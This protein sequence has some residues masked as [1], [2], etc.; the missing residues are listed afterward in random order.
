[1]SDV[2]EIEAEVNESVGGT[3]GVAGY[4]YLPDKPSINGVTLVDNK[5]AASLGL[6]DDVQ[7]DGES[8]VD[9]SV[10]NLTP[11]SGGSTSS[12]VNKAGL[13]PKPPTI[14]ETG[15][16]HILTDNGWKEATPQPDSSIPWATKYSPTFSG[17]P[18]APTAAVGTNT[19]QIATTAF[20]HDEILEVPKVYCGEEAPE[21]PNAMVW[22]DTNGDPYPMEEEIAEAVDEWVTAHPEAVTTVQDGAV[23]KPKLDSNLKSKIDLVDTNATHIANLDA[24]VNNLATLQEGSTTGDAELIAARTVGSTTYQNLHTAIDTEFTNVKS[25]LD[26]IATFSS[27]RFDSDSLSRGDYLYPDG[28]IEP[29]ANYSTTDYIPVSSGET[30]YWW[31]KH[32]SVGWYSFPARCLCAYDASKNAVS[33]S[34]G[35]WIGGTYAVPSGISFIRLTISHEYIDSCDKFYLGKYPIADADSKYLAYG[36]NHLF[37]EPQVTENTSNISVLASQFK[38]VNLFDKTAITADSY[39]NPSDGTIIGGEGFFASDFIDVSKYQTIKVSKT[40]LFALYKADKTYLSAPSNTNSIYADLSV[41]VS[42]A[43]Y[44]R[45]S[46]WD[47]YLNDAQVGQNISSANYAPY[48]KFV[49]PNLIIE[50]EQNQIVVDASGNG[51]YTSFT[52]ALYDNVNSGIDILVKAGTYDIVAEYEALFG[53]ENVANMADSDSAIFN[54]FQFGVI[55]S[56]RKIEFASGAHLVCDW[57][58][59]VVDATHRFCP[60]R[61]DYNVEIIGLDLNATATFYA[62]HDDYGLVDEPYTVKYENCRVSGDFV[63]GNC[64]GGG[65]KAYSRHIINNCWFDNGSGLTAVRYHNTN[66][67]GAEPEIYVSNSYFSSRLTFNYYGLQTTKMKAY[68]NNCKAS[69]IVKIQESESYSVDNVELHKWCCEET[70]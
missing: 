14:E 46:T 41:D 40:H 35:Y 64:I 63:N 12:A 11:F 27:N 33:A 50:N 37:I 58:G 68:V 20:V 25:D 13:V 48:G 32:P 5:S 26:S 54:G 56:N 22:V 69:S 59:H 65:C 15:Q 44:I 53:A 38:F 49:M 51:D 10:A 23:S 62:I 19:T 67:V 8:V 1:M 61:V 16:W 29:D 17:I 66:A 43:S 28:T 3:G 39:V 24:L 6:V 4:H 45:F 18:K 30:V 2:I 9:G 47:E 36:E 21:D 60:L 57:T 55:L 42:G 70:V 7:Q 34:G 31:C 52:E